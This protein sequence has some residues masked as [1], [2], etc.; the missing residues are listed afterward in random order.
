[1][2]VSVHAE[3]RGHKKWQWCDMDNTLDDAVIRVA[4]L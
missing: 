2:F 3:V 4:V 1:M